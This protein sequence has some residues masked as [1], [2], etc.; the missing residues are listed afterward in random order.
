MREIDKTEDR[1]ITELARERTEETSGGF[2]IDYG[3]LL[4]SLNDCVYLLNDKGYFVFINGPI[5]QGSGIA[6]DNFIGLH[7]L[8]VV[9]PKDREQAWMSFEKVMRGEE[10]PAYEVEYAMSDGRRLFVEFS[11]SP[12]YESNKVIGLQ[13]VS[14]N[15]TERRMAEERMRFLSSA[16]EQSS[17]GIAISDLGGDLLYLNEAFAKMHAYG[18]EELI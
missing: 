2:K 18:P 7:L 10:V 9:P 4:E 12:I 1:I 16:G 14:R 8:N 17:E 3:T 6:L 11:T 13:G 15:V 5:E